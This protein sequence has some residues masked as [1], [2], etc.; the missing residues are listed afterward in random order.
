MKM[1]AAI[2]MLVTTPVM[3]GMPAQAAVQQDQQQAQN[4]AQDQ[5]QDKQ[6]PVSYTHLTLP[7]KA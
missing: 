3:F 2:A 1:L 6:I 4:Q 5:D 7:T